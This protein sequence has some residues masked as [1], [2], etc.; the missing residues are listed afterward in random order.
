MYYSK[1]EGII[2]KH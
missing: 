2:Q 1:E